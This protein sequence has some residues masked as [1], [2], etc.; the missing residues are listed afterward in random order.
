MNQIELG[1]DQFEGKETPD[2]EAGLSAVAVTEM[3]QGLVWRESHQR[4]VV[5][6]FFS[7]PECPDD[8]NR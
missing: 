3:G 4:G 7:A 5:G 8:A 2:S 1:H 6:D